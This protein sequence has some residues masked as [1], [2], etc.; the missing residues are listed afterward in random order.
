MI[1]LTDRLTERPT[2]RLTPIDPDHPGPTPS[3]EG[4]L[5]EVRMIQAQLQEMKAFTT[6]T[7]APGHSPQQLPAVPTLARGGKGRAR[8]SKQTPRGSA[9]GP[10][11]VATTDGG[12][13]AL[14]G[15]AV[16]MGGDRGHDDAFAAVVAEQRSM[17]SMQLQT[18]VAEGR[19]D[20]ARCLEA[21]IVE[22]EA[23][24]QQG[25]G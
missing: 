16:A 21:S 2:D 9:S 1:S 17:L 18:A 13:A 15:G 25:A 24:S 3:Q 22:L 19:V 10:S 7:A 5:D 8:S 20:D 6:E 14:G 11:V 23:Y 12:T 4:R